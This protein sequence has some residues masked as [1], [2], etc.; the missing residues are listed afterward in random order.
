MKE[1]KD[2]VV[3]GVLISQV[4]P[5]SRETEG[6]T[7]AA[8]GKVL[9]DG[10][11]EAFQ[12]VE[13]PYADER[14]EI[15]R[16]LSERGYPL[17]YCIARVLNE[18]GSNLSDLDAANRE[19]SYQRA[20]AA[21]QD[22]REIGARFFTVVSGRGPADPSR[23]PEALEG[24]ADSMSQI[25]RAAREDS[26]LEIVIEPLDYAAH[27]KAALGTAEEAL[28]LCDRVREDGSELRLCLDTAHMYLN[29]EDPVA[30]VQKAGD[31]M[32]EFHFCNCVTEP[33][34]ELFGDRHLRFDQPGRVNV[35]TMART[36]SDL[37]ERGL[38][39]EDR[40]THVFCE[41]LTT[42]DRAPEDT[43]AH[44]KE[45]LLAAWERAQSTI[46]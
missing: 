43:L 32:R 22:A 1:L 4:W 13:V 36:L 35:E 24:L 33:G 39:N 6:A 31:R 9:D 8:I 10:F 27:K 3:P 28:I 2:F 14:K 42:G 18:S 5:T 20:I 19:K 26:E 17:T 46:A 23:R 34:H 11:Y 38:L 41:V 40:K 45:T 30:Q 29:D 25:C 7:L 12:T 15:A 21:L 37:L 44:G 16:V